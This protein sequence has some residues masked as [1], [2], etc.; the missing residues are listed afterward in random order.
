MVIQHP[1]PPR[2][3]LMY[4][5]QVPSVDV[6]DMTID[7]VGSLMAEVSTIFMITSPEYLGR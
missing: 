5:H 3:Q 1:F 2:S 4:T 7:I 6:P